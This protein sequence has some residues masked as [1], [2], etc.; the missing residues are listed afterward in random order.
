M[1]KI[2]VGNSYITN[3]ELSCGEIEKTEFEISP[4]FQPVSFEEEDAEK[5]KA[6]LEEHYKSKNIIAEIVIEDI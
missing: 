3:I 4:Y 6:K 2:R 1:K 5:I